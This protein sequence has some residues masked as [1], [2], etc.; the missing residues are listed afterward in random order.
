MG[1]VGPAQQAGAIDLV[2][3]GS[4]ENNNGFNGNN[5]GFG[6]YNDSDANVFD[7]YDHVAQSYNPAGTLDPPGQVNGT[8]IRLA[9]ATRPAST[10]TWT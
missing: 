9:S 5:S 1:F 4:F 7:V 6:W 3:N 2:V 10:K 8:S